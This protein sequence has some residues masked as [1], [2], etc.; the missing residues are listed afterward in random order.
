MLYLFA[1]TKTIGGVLKL[2][3]ICLFSVGSTGTIS[4]AQTPELHANGIS[5]R[6]VQIPMP[7]GANL[8]AD[9]YLPEKASDTTRFP[10]ILEYLP[11]RK[12][13][14]RT[15]RFPFYSY[16]V[17]W[18]YMVVRVDIRG[19]G[20]SSGKLAD[21]EYSEQELA[22]GEVVIDWLSKQ[23]YSTGSVAMMGISWGG[24]NALQLAM[25]KPPALKTIIS[26]MSTDDLYQDDVHFMDG[27]MHIDAYEIGQDLANILP[28]APDFIIDENYFKNRF[29]T[30][31]WLLKYKRQQLD[32][33]FWDRASLN[34]DY[35]SIDIPVFILGG[36]YDGYRDFIPR[37]LQHADVPVK[38]ILGP[39]NHTWPNTASPGP[40]IEWR[41]EAVRW[42]D[43]WLKG[44]ENGVD[45]EQGLVYYQRDYHEPGTALKYIPGSWKFSDSWPQ[46]QDT[47]LFLQP[48]HHLASRPIPF[49][50]QM[51]YLP[52][53][54]V[55]ASGSVMWWGDWAPDQANSDNHSLNYDS[56]IVQDTIEILGFPSVN[57]WVSATVTQANW[58][59]RLLDV[60]PDGK[61]TLITGAGFNGTHLQSAK[62]PVPLVPGSKYNI[63]IE[64]HAT[65]WTF[66]PGHRIR[67]SVSNAQ[68]PMF[69]PSPFPMNTGLHS[70]QERPSNL[71][72][73]LS[74]QGK[75]SPLIRPFLSPVRDPNLPGYESLTAGTLSGF[76]EVSGIARDSLR[77]TT[78]VTATN[79]G[80][81]HYPWGE[82]HYSEFIR[83]TTNNN[84]P[85]S[86]QVESTYINKVILPERTLTFTGVLNFWSDLEN[87]Y[88][89]YRRKL[90]ENN[91]TIREKE[92]VETIKRQ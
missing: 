50:D 31:P 61:V 82:I 15:H 20:R 72:L 17:K 89:R 63:P 21:G 86:T 3:G 19:T 41:D 83:H 81:D 7:D 80:G 1:N 58:I 38:A 2:F 45:K 88:Y 90:E 57:L 25:R 22:D 70:E 85:D 55:E 24:F 75:T 36:W 65:S 68:W 43:Y 10:I 39:W 40:A 69:W 71:K 16:F 13:E 53:A 34:T 8:A 12:D 32:G 44:T 66:H 54:G 74:V 18:G 42:L 73:P 6:E 87:F 51:T 46:T 62:H 4:F 48:Q 37:M 56:E 23:P 49:N 29:D 11:Y 91:L 26:L 30:E 14:G 28:G 33:P 35:E 60:A 27:I 59:V 76:A 47:I 9:V 77:N 78:S 79:S 5:I 84:K 67:L 52:S 92:W 64:M